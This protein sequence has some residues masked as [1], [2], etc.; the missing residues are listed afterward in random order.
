[1]RDVDVHDVV[2]LGDVHHAAGHLPLLQ[3]GQEQPHATLQP[4]Q[5]LPLPRRQVRRAVRVTQRLRLT[6]QNSS[7][8]LQPGLRPTLRL[9]QLF[10]SRTTASVGP[11]ERSVC[12]AAV[13]PTTA[14][15]FRGFSTLEYFGQELAFVGAD[16]PEA[17]MT[18]PS[19]SLGGRRGNV[20][21]PSRC[22]GHPLESVSVLCSAPMLRD[23][24]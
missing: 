4:Q 24:R 10:Y 7:R 1:M 18:L 23:C 3:Q 14:L 12:T 6:S 21:V 19:R 16:F 17:L 15:A 2:P 11:A 13:L 20:W 5:P 8:D 22:P 9:R